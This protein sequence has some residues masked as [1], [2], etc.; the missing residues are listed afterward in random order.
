[1]SIINEIVLLNSPSSV[2]MYKS[3]SIYRATNTEWKSSVWY[4]Q[5]FPV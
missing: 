2:M 3:D 1:M 4:R 5:K